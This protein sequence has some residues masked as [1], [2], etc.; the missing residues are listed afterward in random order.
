MARS[1]QPDPKNRNAR[2]YDDDG[3]LLGG[4]EA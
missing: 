2:L 1:L 3:T 4:I